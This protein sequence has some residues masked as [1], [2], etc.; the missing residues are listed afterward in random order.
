MQNVNI[1][2]RTDTI[3]NNS[4]VSS[5]KKLFLRCGAV[6]DRSH[7]FIVWKSSP[8]VKLISFTNVY[9]FSN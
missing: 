5:S 8:L 1:L 3:E 2:S 9:N 7:F 6:N 4:Y